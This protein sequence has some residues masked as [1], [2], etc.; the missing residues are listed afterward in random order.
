[1]NVVSEMLAR[2]SGAVMAA[3]EVAE[4]A[5]GRGEGDSIHLQAFSMDHDQS[6][7]PRVDSLP[8]LAAY[9]AAT[10]EDINIEVVIGPIQGARL[11]WAMADTSMAGDDNWQTCQRPDEVDPALYFRIDR[12]N[13]AFETVMQIRASSPSK[14]AARRSWTHSRSTIS[15]AHLRAIQEKRFLLTRSSDLPEGAEEVLWVWV[16][17]LSEYG[18]QMV[19]EL[20]LPRTAFASIARPFFRESVEGAREQLFAVG[21]SS[22]LY[23][24]LLL[25]QQILGGIAVS[26]LRLAREVSALVAE[27]ALAAKQEL[28]A[29]ILA[30]CMRGLLGAR[31]AEGGSLRDSLESVLAQLC[32]LPG[33]VEI[34]V[35]CTDSAD[36]ALLFKSSARREAG[37][38]FRAE[39]EE[40]SVAGAGGTLASTNSQCQTQTQSQIPE[41]AEPQMPA[42]SLD[43]CE[44]AL[45]CHEVKGNLTVELDGRGDA[46]QTSVLELI[47]RALARRVYEMNRARKSKVAL[48]KKADELATAM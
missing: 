44:F 15:R 38:A 32:R 3:T 39:V 41:F 10:A 36:R 18:A 48:R 16:E 11:H 6:H 4:S 22:Q 5:G 2:V 30:G 43:K 45:D 21:R 8:S 14:R 23:S 12:A 46:L 37:G 19:L 26:V 25:A 27:K 13:A 34:C 7:S 9:I 1:M 28:L 29:D 47:A 24:K 20:R 42:Y 40:Y 33:V 35:E 17:L 31:S